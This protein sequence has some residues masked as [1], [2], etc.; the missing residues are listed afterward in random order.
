MPQRAM[1]YIDGFSLYFGLREMGWSRYYWLNVKSLCEKFAKPPQR[2]L[3]GVKY[4]TSRVKGNPDKV[5]RQDAFI[6]ALETVPNIDILYGKYG[7]RGYKC[8]R[9]SYKGLLPAEK[10]TDV[11]IASEMLLDASQNKYDIAYL[12][13]GDKDLVPVI[14][15]IKGTFP[16]RCIVLIPPPMRYCSD[17]VAVAHVTLKMWEY[18]IKKSQFP[19]T[20]TRPNAMPLTR[21]L[22]WA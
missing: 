2:Q 12:I 4:F 10:M 18:Y 22:S 16:S 13:S 15:T 17:L 8:Q 20:I 7:T 19:E 11:Y 6:Q 5:A 3:E 1:A 14:K 9:C 21:P